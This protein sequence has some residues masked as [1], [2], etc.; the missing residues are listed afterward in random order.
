MENIVS[1]YDNTINDSVLKFNEHQPLLSDAEKHAFVM[2]V[3]VGLDI[4]EVMTT[5]FEEL[6]TKLAII[7]ISIQSAAG[8]WQVGKESQTYQKTLTVDQ[9]VTF[10]ARIQYRFSRTLSL[11]EWQMLRDYHQ[12]VRHSVKNAIAFYSV[13]KLA[14]KDKLTSLG[15]RLSFDETFNK[16]VSQSRRNKDS[17]SLILIDLDKFKP[18]NDIFGHS[19]GDRVLMAIADAINASLRSADH[20]FRFGGDEFCCVALN[21]SRED[22]QLIVERINQQIQQNKVLQKHKISCSF[23][24]ATLNEEE[25]EQELFDRAD[26][27]LYQAKEAGRDC[28]IIA[29]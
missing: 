25:S 2:Q 14:M 23:G 17:L 8:N 13:Q 7:G 11:R 3:S 29:A 27:A 5:L 22:N 4:Q 24:I 15:N 9:S 18:V 26:K 28:T 6:S 10:S 20:A 1:Y 16:L 19:E 12:C 21:S